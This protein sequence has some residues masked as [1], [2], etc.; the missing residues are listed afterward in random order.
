M[1]NCCDGDQDLKSQRIHDE[2]Q[3]HGKETEMAEVAPV[4]KLS[5][6]RQ[7]SLSCQREGNEDLEG[8]GRSHSSLADKEEREVIPPKPGTVSPSSP[9]RPGKSSM[10]SFSSSS[11]C[12]LS[13]EEP[14][15]SSSPM[16]E[17]RSEPRD[18]NN[19]STRSLLDTSHAQ[20]EETNSLEK[21][22]LYWDCAICFC[23]NPSN[24]TTCSTCG[25]VSKTSEL[26]KKGC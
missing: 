9:P 25:A 17:A 8:E 20:E 26:E 12:V 3:C 10:T 24:R 21:F 11:P 23:I 5:E 7:K 14:S 15:L 6:S 13:H 2:P 19:Q 4:P 22:C 16:R 18:I 1:G